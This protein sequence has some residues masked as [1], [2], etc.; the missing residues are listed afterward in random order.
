MTLYSG[1]LDGEI[2]VW[3]LGDPDGLPAAANGQWYHVAML[4]GHTNAVL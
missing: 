4:T 2:R 1:S 3:S